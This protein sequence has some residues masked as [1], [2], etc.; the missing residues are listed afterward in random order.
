MVGLWD[1]P[2]KGIS[3]KVRSLTVAGRLMK[4]L[5]GQIE[6]T[7]EGMNWVREREQIAKEV[8]EA[9]HV[10]SDFLASR[11]WRTSTS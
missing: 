10:S 5:T 7:E 9:M 11:D 2:K 1:G 3:V 6:W 8:G 4:C